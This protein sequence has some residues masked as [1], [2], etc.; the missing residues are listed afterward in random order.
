MAARG[1]EDRDLDETKV[2]VALRKS[3]RESKTKPEIR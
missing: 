3:A 2:K 1:G